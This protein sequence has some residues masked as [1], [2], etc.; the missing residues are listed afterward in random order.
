M[1]SKYKVVLHYCRAL[2][3]GFQFPPTLPPQIV[4]IVESALDDVSGS[5][6]ALST[7]S[8]IVSLSGHCLKWANSNGTPDYPG[9]QLEKFLLLNQVIIRGCEQVFVAGAEFCGCALALLSDK[10]EN[11]NTSPQNRNLAETTFDVLKT[12]AENATTSQRMDIL[13]DVIEDHS[14]IKLNKAIPWNK[15]QAIHK[16]LKERNRLRCRVKTGQAIHVA[17]DHARNSVLTS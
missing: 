8:T 1:G 9:G 17:V 11:N 3:N 16:R 13:I 10:S 4:S 5:K 6:A 15:C 14:C 12:L 2:K 7:V